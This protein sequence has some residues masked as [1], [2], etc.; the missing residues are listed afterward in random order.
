MRSSVTFPFSA[1]FHQC[2]P[3]LT[4]LKIGSPEELSPPF[5]D[6]V[7]LYSTSLPNEITTHRRTLSNPVRPETPSPSFGGVSKSAHQTSYLKDFSSSFHY[8]PFNWKELR[9]TTS[10]STGGYNTPKSR[11]SR[12][13]TPPNSSGPSTAN[14]AGSPSIEPTVAEMSDKDDESAKEQT[15]IFELPPFEYHGKIHFHS[16]DPIF[17]TTSESC[18][19]STDNST[20]E[21]FLN[22]C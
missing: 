6:Q 3:S 5:K 20:N 4:P 13:E 21:F 7:G 9:K 16:D 14:A 15:N 11:R 8:K 17:N 10:S 19:T 18:R 2:P 22:R 12:S 1:Q